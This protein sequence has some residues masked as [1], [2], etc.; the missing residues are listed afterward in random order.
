M[1]NTC[2]S[3][4]DKAQEF[5]VQSGAGFRFCDSILSQ[6]WITGWIGW[7]NNI[8]GKVNKII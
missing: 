2:A 6:Y 4:H 5:E 3:L 8:N 1:S 7:K